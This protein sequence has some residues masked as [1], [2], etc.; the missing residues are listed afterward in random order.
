[1]QYLEE[2]LTT[3]S[4]LITWVFIMVSVPKYA[5]GII[6]ICLFAFVLYRLNTFCY[7]DNLLDYLSYFLQKILEGILT[8]MGLESMF[9]K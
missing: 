6:I 4:I 3:L 8:H 7:G 2:R 9:G 1:M 5:D